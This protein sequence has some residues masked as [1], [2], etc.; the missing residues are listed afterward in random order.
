MDTQER[1]DVEETTQAAQE[2]WEVAP[3]VD[4]KSSA[5]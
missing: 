3:C 4:V 1:E 2:V 5:S